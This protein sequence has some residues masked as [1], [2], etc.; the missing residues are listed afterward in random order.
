VS[1]LVSRRLGPSVVHV[2]LL[3]DETT[4]QRYEKFLGN[5]NPNV[6]YEGQGSG[7]VIDRE[8]HI[9][10]NHHVLGNHSRIEVTLSDGRRLMADVVGSDP[11][12]DLAVLKV[13]APNLMPIEWGNSNDVVVGSPVWAVGSPY[14]LHQTVTFGIVSGKHRLDLRG[15]RYEDNL[16]GEAAYGDLMQSDVAVNPGNSGGP[17]GNSL[18][19]VIG[20]NAAILGES[21]RGISFSIPSNVAQRIASSLIQSGEVARGWLGIEM[22]ELSTA[23]RVA[24]DGQVKPGVRVVAFPENMLSPAREAGLKVGDVIVAYQS[25]PVMNKTELQSLIGQTE[26]GAKVELKVVRDGKPLDLVVTI[27]RRSNKL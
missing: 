6:R 4:V 24:K 12:T 20:V 22:A 14:G 8:G 3:R 18:G 5:N 19:Q 27:A 1:Q 17:L 2:N 15:T 9:L 25:Q 21:Y 13:N 16:L 23:D 11:K 7:F 26:V 10:T